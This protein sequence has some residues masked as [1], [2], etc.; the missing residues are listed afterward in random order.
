LFHKILSGNSDFCHVSVIDDINRESRLFVDL[1]RCLQIRHRSKS[2]TENNRVWH[3][4][5][6]AFGKSL[7]APYVIGTFANGVIAVSNA[8]LYSATCAGAVET[9]FEMMPVEA[10]R[11]LQELLFLKQLGLLF[12][13]LGFG[14]DQ[15]ILFLNQSVLLF[16]EASL[17]L[18]EPLLAV[19]EL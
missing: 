8:D 2:Q 12:Q 18:D 7:A 1:F 9:A 10:R 11:E 14:V 17:A 13:H 3:R 6:E 4:E 15:F 5:I 16:D 19:D